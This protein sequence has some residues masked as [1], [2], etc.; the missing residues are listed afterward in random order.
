M[1]RH[2][3]KSLLTLAEVAFAA[4][5]AKLAHLNRQECAL[6]DQLTNLVADRNEQAREGPSDSPAKRAGADV[7]WHRWIDT[8]RE[9][10]NRELAQI[11][12][13]RTRVVADVRRS[14]GKKE[15]LAAL[16]AKAGAS[17]ALEKSRRRDQTS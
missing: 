2:E 4:E 14:F 5:Q 9:T 1:K 10:L 15:A 13:R 16:C 17:E 8:R 12:A 7:R 6:R 3:I 11:L